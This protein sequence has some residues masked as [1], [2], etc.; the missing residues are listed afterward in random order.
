MP[1]LPS[2]SHA[3]LAALGHDWIRLIESAN[4][5]GLDDQPANAQ[6]AEAML[7]QSDDAWSDVSSEAKQLLR[8]GLWLL[9]GDLDRSHNI[10]QN[11]ASAE[12]SFL[13]GIMHRREG[14]FGNAKYWFRK[15]GDHPVI[16]ELVSKATSVYSGSYEF[17]DSCQQAMNQADPV[18]IRQC[19]EMQW[20]E[21]V[22]LMGHCI[23]LTSH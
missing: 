9:A 4:S 5:P 22:C 17:V 16:D 3:T 15:V 20:T 8:S 19:K 23:A 21:W 11:L 18:K 1:Q 7:H 10:S 13:H 14:D 12:G 6:L 2:D